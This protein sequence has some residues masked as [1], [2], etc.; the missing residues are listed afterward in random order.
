[1]S[2][3]TSVCCRENAVLV[4]IDIQDRL[5]AVMDRRD[6]VV[7]AVDKLVRTAALLGVPIIATRQYPKG[8]GDTDSGLVATLEELEA[9]GATV[10]RAD[11]VSF[12]CFLEPSFARAVSDVG[13]SQLIVVGMETHI[14]IAQTVLHAL[15]EGLSVHVAA[16][17]CCSR[18]ERAHDLALDRMRAAGA[19]ISVSESAMYEL[20]GEAGT[21][22][23]RG[24][25]K[26]VKG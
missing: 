20:V 2:D 23:F 22:E 9:G 3:Q 19:V 1:M 11:K 25:L 24:L 21:D 15:A 5:A 7:G 16:D 12:D 10:L 17:A 4:V 14:C 13:R 8:L 6:E 26:I 18:D